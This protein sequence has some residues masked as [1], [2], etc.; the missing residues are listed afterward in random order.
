VTGSSFNWTISG[1]ATFSGGSTTA[2]GD[3]VTVNVANNI[4]F[5]SF[6][7]TLTVSK[8]GC[9]SSTCEKTVDVLAPSVVTDTERCTLPNSQFRLIYT[10]DVQNMPAYKLTASNPGQFFYNVFYTGNPGAQLPDTLTVTLPYPFETQ[11]ANPTHAYDNVTFVNSGGKTCLTP[12]NEVFVDSQTVDVGTSCSAV[13]S[14]TPKTITLN[15]KGLRV[16]S[17]GVLF[18][19]I[20]VDY[21]FKKVC[22]GY[23][24]NAASDAVDFATKLTTLIP[25]LGNYQFSFSFDGGSPSGN[26]SVQNVNDFKKNPGVGGMVQKDITTNPVPGATG[27]LKNASGTLVGSATTDLDGYY[28]ITY[29]HTGPRENYTVTIVKG[30]YQDTKTVELKANAFFQVDFNIPSL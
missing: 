15:T 29:K 23:D 13:G 3:T 22:S 26:T 16:Q 24:K 2:T 28:Q 9:S 12:G 20:H 1:N 11:G 4:A 27:T 8:N 25:N 30:T 19:A 17:S 5:G 6:K 10:Q 21:G 7:L 18:F 14:G